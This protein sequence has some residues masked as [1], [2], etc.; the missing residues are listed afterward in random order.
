MFKHMT[1]HMLLLPSGLVHVGLCLKRLE[2]VR[3]C[4]AVMS[5]VGRRRFDIF[6]SVDVCGWEYFV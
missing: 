6:L 2:S 1:C 3:Y 5:R 4:V